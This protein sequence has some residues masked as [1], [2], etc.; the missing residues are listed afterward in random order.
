MAADIKACIFDVFG[1]VVDWRTSVSRDLAAFAASKGITGIDWLA[2]AVAWRKLYQPAMEEVRS[3]RRPFTILD[4]LHRESLVR[5]IGEFAIKELSEAD[6]DH[7]NRAWHRLDPWPDAVAGLTRLKTKHIIAPCSNGNIA[8]I[9]NMAKRA[10][11]PWDCVLGAE[12]A[13][14]FKPTPEAYLAAC[15]MLDLEPAQVL[16][17]AAHNGDLKAAKAQG[18]ATAFVARPTEHGPDQ[19]TDLVADASVVDIPAESFINL[20]QKLGC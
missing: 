17:V 6:I 8:L 1:T 3:G 16:M 14:A 11:L 20:A 12:T 10:G 2:F 7:M 9:V 19:K 5:L 13:R 15:R 4:V 18:L